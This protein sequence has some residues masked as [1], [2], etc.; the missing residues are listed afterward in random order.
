MIHRSLILMTPAEAFRRFTIRCDTT[1]PYPCQVLLWGNDELKVKMAV[2][3]LV[4]LMTMPEPAET[5]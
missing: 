3:V 1:D 5:K 2:D 4:Q